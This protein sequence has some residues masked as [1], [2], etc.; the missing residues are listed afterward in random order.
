MA[1]DAEKLDL[2]IDEKP[3]RKRQQR[4][5]LTKRLY[6]LPYW[7][8][9]MILAWFY[10]VYQMSFNPDYAEA[11]VALR[12]GIPL[13]L[14]LAVAS[15]ALALVFGLIIG[16]IRANPPEAPDSDLPPLK[17]A[18]RILQ[19]F[20]YNAVTVYVEFMRGIPPLVF[21]LIA[22]FIIVPAIR[23]PVQ[24]A[25]NGTILPIVR[26]FFP[27]T[28][29][30]VWRGRDPLTA[31]AGLS[32]IYAAFLS[33]VFR[34]GLQ[35]V[36]KGQIEAAKSVGMNWFQTMRFVVVPQAVRNVLPPL[37]N[38][39]I[40]MIKDTSLVTILATS[41]ITQL[42]RRWA[43]S[44]FTYLETYLVLSLMYL[45]ITVTGSLLVQLMENRLQQH[46]RD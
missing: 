31:I 3:K 22:G 44:K 36:P 42:A 19:V 1:T 25:Y 35:S 41:E 23:E 40:S 16:T 6:K 43:G 15:Y 10:V 26:Q 45:T 32:M 38:D 11:Y 20:V 8:F 7:L 4:S 27:E 13:T 39:F 29:E 2:P 14:W 46:S 24:D 5:Q 9:F 17:Q 21:L 33:E 12:E 28:G 37:G 30:W 34:A 18:V